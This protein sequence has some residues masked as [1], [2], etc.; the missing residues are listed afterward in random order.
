ML[1][2]VKRLFGKTTPKARFS[3]DNY[4]R[5]Y[6]LKKQGLERVLGP[7]HDL[8]IHALIPF[9]V[10]GPVDLYRFQ[11]AIDGTVFAT[12]E[13]IEP[14]GSG[15]KPSSIGTYELLAAT[16][17]RLS[18]AGDDPNETTVIHIRKILTTAARYSLEEVLNPGDT[19][20]VP[21]AEKQEGACL[22]LDEWKNGNV[23]FTIGSQKHGLLLCMEVFRSEMEYA[24]QHGSQPLFERLKAKGYYPY[25][26]MNR[27]PV[28]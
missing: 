24:M 14:D 6:Q 11:H 22:V 20:E 17:H 15:P 25:C 4:E 26:D 23:G 7:T 21:P 19:C 1:D 27:D 9:Q 28:V 5:S 18:D 2:A 3:D 16:R 13:L 10:G 12:M 8:V